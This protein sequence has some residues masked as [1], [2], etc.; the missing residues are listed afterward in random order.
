MC[1]LIPVTL[2]EFCNCYI[3]LFSVGCEAAGGVHVLQCPCGCEGDHAAHSYGGA[4]EHDA[5]A[6]G[7]R[8]DGV[9]QGQD[10]AGVQ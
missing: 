1:L 5:G 2:S 4:S 3:G 10:R 6:R 9:P 8:E 7:G